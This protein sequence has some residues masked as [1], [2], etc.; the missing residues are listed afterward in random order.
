MRKIFSY[1]QVQGFE[2]LP[3]TECLE[4]VF[5]PDFKTTSCPVILDFLIRHGFIGPE[6]E[7]HFTEVIELLHV[8][9]SNLFKYSRPK[10]IENGGD[11]N[12]Q[13]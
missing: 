6:K 1:G 7:K 3:A 2:L 13:K 12:G 9:L 8:P 4:R 5:S 11:K 10:T